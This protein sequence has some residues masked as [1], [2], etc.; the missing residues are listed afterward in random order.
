MIVKQLPRLG[1][2][3]KSGLIIFFLKKDQAVGVVVMLLLFNI[4]SELPG[5]WYFV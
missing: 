3:S 4:F 2:D 1:T 5:L